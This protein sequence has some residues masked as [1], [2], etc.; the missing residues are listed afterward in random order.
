MKQPKLA[1]S[2]PC[3]VV[4]SDVRCR[5]IG[6]NHHGRNTYFFQLAIGRWFGIVISFQYSGSLNSR[7]GVCWSFRLNWARVVCAGHR[8]VVPWGR[9]GT[10]FHLRRSITDLVLCHARRVPLMVFGHR[11]RPMRGSR[12][13][14][15][16]DQLFAS[17]SQLSAFPCT[18][19][20]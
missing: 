5:R 4:L 8:A 2:I 18:T 11:H 15:G 19:I 13:L 9:M 10:I 3:H 14:A 16:H 7:S 17:L 12:V 6:K 1:K 20:M